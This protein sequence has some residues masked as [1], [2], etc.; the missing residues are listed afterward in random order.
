MDYDTQPFCSMICPEIT[1]R[2]ALHSLCQ[3]HTHPCPPRLFVL[4]LGDNGDAGEGA[5]EPAGSDDGLPTGLRIDPTD[6]RWEACHADEK[7]RNQDLAVIINGDA[8]EA[9][10]DS[11]YGDKSLSTSYRID[12]GD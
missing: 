10:E 12:F 1:A 5:E 3:H 4:L 7:G 8:K 11:A 6:A 9:I 2:Y